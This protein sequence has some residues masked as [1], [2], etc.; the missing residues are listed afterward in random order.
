MAL[1][2][3]PPQSN[4]DQPAFVLLEPQELSIY[5]GQQWTRRVVPQSGDIVFTYEAT[6]NRYGIICEDFRGCLGRRMAL[7]RPDEAKIDSFL[8]LQCLLSNQWREE[9]RS[10][11]I[12]GATVDRI[13]L[14]T[15]PSFQV[16]VPGPEARRRISPTIRACEELAENCRRRNDVLRRTRDLLL[17]KLVSGEIE[18]PDADKVLEGVTA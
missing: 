6:L 14:T 10:K 11:T 8:L 3:S 5:L 15:F 17:P 13:P 16:S 1:S 18:I 12:S 2:R 7:I 9:V 4:G